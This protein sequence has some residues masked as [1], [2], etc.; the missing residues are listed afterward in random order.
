MFTPSVVHDGRGRSGNNNVCSLRVIPR[1][2]VLTPGRL[3]LYDT[4][5]HTRFPVLPS[6]SRTETCEKELKRNL[7]LRV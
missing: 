2:S 4:T 7:T 5:T 6:T 1:H 3:V